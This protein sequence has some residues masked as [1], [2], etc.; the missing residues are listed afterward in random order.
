MGASRLEH[1]ELAEP[2]GRWIAEQ[3]FDLLTGGGTGTMEAVC[4]GFRSVPGRK[5][6]AVGVLPAGERPGYPNPHLDFVI[7]THLPALGK[8]GN[9]ERSR[10][11][12]NILSSD[13]VVA[14]PG[15]PGTCSEVELS[16]RYGKPVVAYLGNGGSI[17][18]LASGVV[19]IARTLAEVQAFVQQRG[20]PN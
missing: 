10:N 12:I 9:S 1:A 13:L 5:G 7:R 2:L 6:I 17:D 16:L 3:G 11:H 20:K 19:P 8:E 4:R 18:G 15:G 14:L